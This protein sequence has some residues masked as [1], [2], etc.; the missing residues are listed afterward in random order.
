[1]NGQLVA[2]S[3]A[4]SPDARLVTPADTFANGAIAKGSGVAISSAPT[5]E[6]MLLFRVRFVKGANRVV[7]C[8]ANDQGLTYFW[9]RVCLQGRPLSAAAA[10]A[11]TQAVA[12]R[13]AAPRAPIMG[14]RN[15][16]RNSYP[17]ATP[18]TTWDWET[19]ANIRWRVP[20]FLPAK[21]S[22]IIAGD[23]VFTLL[24]P[25]VLVCADKL[26]GHILWERESSRLEL[27]DKA[28]YEESKGLFDAYRAV[29]DRVLALGSDEG[30][31]L[32][33]LKA[34]GLTEEAAAAKL[35]EMGD[36]ASKA[37][38][39]WSAFVLTAS[40]AIKWGWSD[41][42]GYSMGTPLTDGH[43]VW[44]KFATGVAACY[45]MD[46]TR[47]WIA[48]IGRVGHWHVATS[49][50]LVGDPATGR[51]WLVMRM[52]V[53]GLD[54]NGKVKATTPHTVTALDAMTGALAWRTEPL[55][56]TCD[57][58]SPVAM[59][60]SN[61]ETDMDVILTQGGAVLRAADGKV[62]IPG[63][64]ADSD[65]STATVAGDVVYQAGGGGRV[66]AY[67][68]LMLD[69]D[70][71]GPRL[72]WSRQTASGFAF[73]AGLA[74]HKGLLYGISGPQ[75]CRSFEVFDAR[76]GFP[77]PRKAPLT[78]TLHGRPYVP[79]VG[80]GDYVFFTENGIPFAGK[81]QYA[82]CWVMKNYPDGEVVGRNKFEKALV[83]SPVFDGDR[84]Y[85]RT[86][87]FLT[88]IAPTAARP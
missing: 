60:L 77:V 69:R 22:P 67:R 41:W 13:L 33:A 82:D 49:P 35:K 11:R 46:G 51:A 16:A 58:A 37:A 57:T 26:T 63:L 3:P 75:D 83:A 30:A 29:R 45:D 14:F 87:S 9:M 84:M 85:V 36:A 76:T 38:S 44:V 27:T 12:K 66:T 40:Q 73:P 21:A 79:T 24:D 28:K 62:L 6:D 39:A 81:K 23:K 32:T 80:A 56:E 19:G 1:M 34:Q 4:V 53:D 61:G 15:D 5:A 55:K 10:Q 20:L 47:T 42:T 86:D 25:G 2:Q 65:S 71:V 88:C 74:L 70:T 17:E 50:I 48:D 31:R 54:A 72:L 52:P 68:L 78:A 64:F 18:A 59:R 7:V 43:H 8:C